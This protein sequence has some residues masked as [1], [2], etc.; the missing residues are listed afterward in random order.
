MENER[1]P[2]S[3]RQVLFTVG[4]SAVFVVL[5]FVGTKVITVPIPGTGGYF[6]LG[7]TFVMVA[8]LLF[9]PVVGLIAGA[10]GPALA[11]VFGF[12]PYAPATFVIKGI[13]GLVVGLIAYQANTGRVVLALV[14]AIAII[15][16]GYFFVQ[17]FLYIWL[18]EHIKMFDITTV[19]GAIG[20]LPFNLLQGALCALIAFGVW[21]VFRGG[22]DD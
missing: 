22:G 20:E 9:G 7:D 6:N 13:E 8:A 11:D 21:R 15:S 4:I 1:K 19:G 10:L 17:A 14:L 18:G 12:L 2:S 3:Q 16:G 5:A